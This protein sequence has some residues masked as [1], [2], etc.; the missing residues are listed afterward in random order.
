MKLKAACMEVGVYQKLKET[1]YKGFVTPENKK[2]ELKCILI[3]STLIDFIDWVVDISPAFIHFLTDSMG[4]I[5]L[6]EIR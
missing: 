5:F 6:T 1:A 4:E 2:S 3:I